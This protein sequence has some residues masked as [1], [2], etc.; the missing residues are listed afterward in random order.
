MGAK[1]TCGDDLGNTF[2]ESVRFDDPMV[3]L[4]KYSEGDGM[5]TFAFPDLSQAI[6]TLAFEFRQAK[7]QMIFTA[8]KPSFLHFKYGEQADDDTADELDDKIKGVDS[9]AAIGIA[10][11]VLDEIVSIKNENMD[12]IEPALNKQLRYFSGATRLPTAFYL[13][14]KD[15]SGMSDVGEKSDMLKI[16]QK[17]E[18]IFSV[19]QPHIIAMFSDVYDITIDKL[20]LPQPVVLEDVEEDKEDNPDNKNETTDKPITESD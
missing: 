8:A 4:I 18:T 1:F 7:G 15:S 16:Y 12:I 9:T 5:S 2:T 11:S 3:H 19:Y 17:K 13:G 10:K 14:E 6:M 20:E